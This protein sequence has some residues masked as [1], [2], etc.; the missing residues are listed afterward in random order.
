RCAAGCLPPIRPLPAALPERWP[1][2]RALDDEARAAL[3]CACGA[4]LRPHVLWFDEAYDEP[5]YR[6]ASALRAVETA[7]ALIVVGTSGATTLPARMCEVIAARG[8]PFLVVDPEPTAFSDLA[9]A[10]ARGHFLRGKAT[11]ILPAL[12]EEIAAAI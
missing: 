12:V 8:A 1:K 5:L 9:A 10:S 11:E 4:W 6:H 3:R 7:A 2:E